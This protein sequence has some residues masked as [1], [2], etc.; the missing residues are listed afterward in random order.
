MAKTKPKEPKPE[1][2]EAAVGQVT[3]RN[4]II[5]DAF[6]EPTH[7]WQFGGQ[8]PEVVE[9]RRDAGYLPPAPEGQQFDITSE[10]I[11][12]NLVNSLRTRVR[13]WR[14]E[15]YPGATPTT[16]R[17]FDYWFDPER[18]RRP[19]FAQREA[20]E[21]IAFLTEAPADRKTGIPIE[22][23][24]EYERWAVKLATGA[25]KTLVMAM[26]IAWSG[27]NKLF[28]KQD[29]RFA[30]AFL[31][32][33]PNLTVK[34]RLEG[35]DGLAPSHEKSAYVEFGLIP[36]EFAGEFGRVKVTVLN[37][38]ALAPKEDP[39]RSVLRRGR[40]SDGAFANRVLRDLGS[41]KRIMVI[42]DEAHHA[43]RSP[44]DMVVKKRGEEAE[45]YEEATVWL[46][47]LERIN[48][49]R[50]ILRAIDFSA[51]PMYPSSMGAGKAFTPFEWVISDFG[52][53]DA[54]ESGMVKI[55]RVPT[56]DNA[57][58]AVPK[59]RNLWEHIKQALPKR[60]DDPSE[61]HDLLDYL[62]EADGPLKQLSGQWH[63]TFE[64]W[65]QAGRP[66]PPVMIIVCNETKMAEMLEIHIGERGEAGPWFQNR[67]DDEGPHT[68]R[69]DSKLLKQA[70]E[71]DDGESATDQE[72]RLRELVNT[73]GREGEPG[74]QVRC[75]ISVSMLS[76]G[77]SAKN[78]TQIL[79]LRAFNSQLLC[80]QVVG[81]G[82]R[83][84]NIG[85][86]EDLRKPEYVDVYGVP[87]Q[88]LPFAKQDGSPPSEPPKVTQVRALKEREELLIRFPRVDQVISDIGDKVEV[89]LD[90]ME[91]VVVTPE[92]DPTRV[93]VEFEIGEPGSG[94]GG[95]TQ[96]RSVAYE[97]FRRQRLVFRLAADLTSDTDGGQNKP[98]LF[99]QFVQI[100]EQVL[101]EKVVFEKGVDEREL[102]NLRYVNE[103]RNRTLASLRSSEVDGLVPA[104][105]KYEPIAT[106]RIATFQTVKDCVPT[107]KSH[108]SHV[109]GDSG[110]ELK[111]AA[112]LEKDDRV[113]SYAKN[114]RLGFDIPYRW[115]GASKR[116]RPDFLIKLEDGTTLIMEGKGRK[117]EKDDAKATAARRWIEAVNQWGELGRW[118]YCICFKKSEVGPLIDEALAST[119]E[120][121]SGQ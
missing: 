61:S 27:L 20:I 48:R 12:M 116:Y 14:E 4:P 83:R 3:D 72:K 89:N 44:P 30:D 51:T 35:E 82:L 114:D 37:W 31:V 107:T 7:H 17:L 115:Q 81:R 105:S 11:R 112:E 117:D 118:Q 42:N 70:E 19:F 54:I 96:D 71:R 100:V 21:T 77:W 18:E 91:P 78:V 106:T 8:E 113:I 75:L 65:T 87:F 92:E 95:K 49:A 58:L 41:K 52:L 53:I 33:A 32:M 67:K 104:L 93:Y 57:G 13:G 60:T 76:E 110:L 46:D 121:V 101:K 108:I 64:S 63:K 84:S 62:S 97:S 56:D 1:D 23:H 45:A 94:M 16:K 99:P 43:W 119:V 40:E 10:L 29:T 6:E 25:G 34:E 36:S 120:S 74:E 38:H 47:G 68:V 109:V 15:G 103:I 24:E 98:W 5:N 39:K 66:M 28:N 80:E 69:I 73:V 22:Q 86:A 90:D 59:Y 55:P 85:S 2:A 26:V 79:G 50:G 102:C 88:L 111:M 9:G